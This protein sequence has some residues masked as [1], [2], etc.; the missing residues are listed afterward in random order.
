VSYTWLYYSMMVM[1]FSFEI[2]LELLSSLL[3]L[4]GSAI[5]KSARLF[6]G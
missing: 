1:V 4:S 2:P 5:V 6:Q 3:F